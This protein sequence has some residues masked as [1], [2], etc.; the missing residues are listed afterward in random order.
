MYI[1]AMLFL[2]EVLLFITFSLSKGQLHGYY[3]RYILCAQR[4][5]TI[6]RIARGENSSGSWPDLNEQERRVYKLQ[7][8]HGFR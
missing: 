8:R 6:V 3:S 2:V 5:G 1:L 7:Q 4:C